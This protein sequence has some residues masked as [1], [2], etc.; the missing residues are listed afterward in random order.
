MYF[1]VNL[2]FFKYKKNYK[3]FNNSLINKKKKNK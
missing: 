2:F 3:L 1:Y